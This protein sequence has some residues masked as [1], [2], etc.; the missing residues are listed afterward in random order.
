LL[1]IGR[2]PSA[3]W[4]R[5]PAGALNPWEAIKDDVKAHDREAYERFFLRTRMSHT[6]GPIMFVRAPAPEFYR[7]HWSE[8]GDAL[9]AAVLRLEE[10]EGTNGADPAGRAPR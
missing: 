7:E 8:F 10:Q 6:D 1:E 5:L 9:E 2:G 3:G 4:F